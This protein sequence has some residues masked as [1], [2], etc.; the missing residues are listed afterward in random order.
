MRNFPVLDGRVKAAHTKV[1]LYFLGQETLS[2]GSATSK[3][4]QLR[5]TMICSFVACMAEFD[6]HGMWMTESASRRARDMGTLSLQAYIRLA[7]QAF[8]YDI[9][10]WKAR[11][12]LHDFQ[13]QLERV[14]VDNY[15]P[16]YHQCLNDEHM[17]GVFKT[18]GKSCH[19]SQCNLALQ[20]RY[21]MVLCRLVDGNT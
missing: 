9:C 13:E 1:L 11:P 21:L 6:S 2:V 12:K 16:Q 17:L 18:I 4:V 20:R 5:S 10:R 3:H 8:R 14:V 19:S 15:N 7:E